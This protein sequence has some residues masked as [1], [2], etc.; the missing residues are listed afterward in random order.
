MVGKIVGVL[1]GGFVALK[2]SIA[3]IPSITGLDG[4]VS[5]ATGGT[6]IIFDIL[7]VALWL[8][9]V[10]AVAG[11]VIWAANQISHWG[12]NDNA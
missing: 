3:L 12:R 7:T 1:L 5:T 8:L 10:A 11:I 4:D 2:I 9:P 6:G